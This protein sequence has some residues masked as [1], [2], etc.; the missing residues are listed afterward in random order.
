MYPAYLMIDFDSKLKTFCTLHR[1]ILF[2]QPKY[3]LGNIPMPSS[4]Q[5]ITILHTSCR[6]VTRGPHRSWDMGGMEKSA[7]DGPK[8]KR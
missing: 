8:Y 1:N 6:P 5:G 3:I 2:Y 4:V 7:H